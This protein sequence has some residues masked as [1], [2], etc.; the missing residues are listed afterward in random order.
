MAARML[1]DKQKAEFMAI[2]G[3]NFKE[4]DS[5]KLSTLF[6]YSKK[7]NGCRFSVEDIMVIGPEDSKYVK[8]GTI[9]TIGI[10]LENKILFEDLGIFGYI[11]KT[12]TG[13]VNGK[14]ESSL[15]K[16][17]AEGDITLEQYTN[18][19]NAAQ[20]LLG[21]PMA[22][23]INT[24]L[25]RTVMTLPPEAAK[26]RKKLLKDNAKELAGNDPA[27]SSKIEHAVVD[28]ALQEMRKTDDPAIALFDAGC[29]IDPYNQYKT[30]MVMKGA[31]QDNT[32]DSPTGY[33]IITSNYDTGITKEDMPKIADAVVTTAY[34]TG[35]STQD[36]GTN[37][38]RY[39]SMFQ[40]IRL[41][42][43]HS[44]CGSKDLDDITL[45]PEI[46][47]NFIYRFIVENGKLK[48]LTPDNIKSYY[49]KTVKMRTANHCKAPDPCYCNVCVG[50]R[51]Y[52]VGV[53]NIGFTFMTI[54]G[55]T[56][57][58]SLKKKHDVSIHMY[59]VS[60]DEILKYV[61]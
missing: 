35:V 55:S 16:A 30:I 32:G 54:S 29:G 47:D 19:I 9:T 50:D 3:P 10:F 25:S 42:P 33:K 5:N 57:N 12:V 45:D 2:A 48:M 61:K 44:D 15:A 11:N 56:L 8:P 28:K 23:I 52:R 38:K 37:G 6:A 49:G 18:Y 27:V 17:L 24:S 41:L 34:S 31:I 40:R 59:D 39:N 1:N 53:R 51:P 58:A 7:A 43:R 60:V 14:I 21:G 46:A 4:I 20:W 13:K 22:F 26:L 36:S